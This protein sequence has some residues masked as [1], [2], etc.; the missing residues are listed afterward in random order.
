MDINYLAP[1]GRAWSRM[2]KAL[3]QPFDPKKWLILGFNVF[4]AGLAGGS[5][6]S[7]GGSPED[8]SGH[9]TFREFLEL[10]EKASRWLVTHPGWVAL[11]TLGAALALIVYAVLTWLS[12]RGTFMFLD[13]VVYDRA[14]VVAPWKRYKRLGNS[15]FLWRLGFTLICLVVLV[16]W[17]A[18]FFTS[19]SHQYA[20]SGDTRIPVLF[21]VEMAVLALFMV[22]VMGYISLFLKSFVVP[23]MARHNLTAIPAW[24]RFLSLFDEA[25]LHFVFYGLFVLALGS[26]AL[27]LVA[28]TGMLTCCVGFLALLIPYLGTVIT[29][30]IWYLFRAFSLEYLGQFGPDYALFPASSGEPR[31][32]RRSPNRR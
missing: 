17:A 12:S 21:I 24:E 14:E 6:G 15:L 23:I 27:T 11:I 9:V 8:A 7:V 19:A 28:V 22:V 10:P 25:P 20:A 2:I 18:F 32:D 31:S 3:F 29:L 26:T 16:L 13:N 4:L 5:H 1:L 30:P